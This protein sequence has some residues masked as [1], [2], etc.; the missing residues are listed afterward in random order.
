M[1]PYISGMHAQPVTNINWQPIW[2]LLSPH[3][4][5]IYFSSL[6]FH[7]VC[8]CQM[9]HA[10]VHPQL[11]SSDSISRRQPEEEAERR[12]NHGR[13]ART[14]TLTRSGSGG[15]GNNAVIMQGTRFW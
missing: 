9:L 14:D 11:S 1:D 12:N 4:I 10:G 7:A 6:S 5:C 13:N 8:S 2:L 3:Y 15:L